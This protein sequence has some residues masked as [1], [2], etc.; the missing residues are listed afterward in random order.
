M[1]G[2]VPGTL[3]GGEGD[4]RMVSDIRLGGRIPPKGL[5]LSCATDDSGATGTPLY[6]KKVRVESGRELSGSF[7][8]T[9]G[10]AGTA[11]GLG[12]GPA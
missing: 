12:K 5:P 11:G 10:V 7:A 9:T 4:P 3:R 8:F 2:T 1:L 6:A